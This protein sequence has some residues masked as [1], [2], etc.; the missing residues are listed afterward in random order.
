MHNKIKLKF[1]IKKAY[2]VMQC[3]SI[4]LS[5]TFMYS[6]KTSEHI[7][8]KFSPSGSHTIL[9]FQHQTLWQY[10]DRDHLMRA[11]NAGGVCKK[12]R[13]LYLVS[14]HVVNSQTAKCDTPWQV[15]DT[16]HL[17]F[18]RD[19]DEVFITRS[20]NIT[21]KTTEQNLIVCSSK[22]ETARTNNKKLRLRYCTVEAN[23]T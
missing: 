22:S 14:S 1:E 10:S 13:F 5:V 21:V 4:R 17:L 20:L 18:T 6:V 2:A 11:S 8:K 23:Y 19:D 3:P 15:G 7:F 16:R 12:S 9:V